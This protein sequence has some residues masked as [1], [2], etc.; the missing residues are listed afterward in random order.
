MVGRMFNVCAITPIMEGCGKME[1]IRRWVEA[2]MMV[3]LLQL[4]LI[5]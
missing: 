4:R 3:K 2:L 5:L 1:P